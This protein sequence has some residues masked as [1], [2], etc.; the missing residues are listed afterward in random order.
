MV[1][2]LPDNAGDAKDEGWIPGSPVSAPTGTSPL[3]CLVLK[4]LIRVRLI[5][6]ASLVAQTVKK[7]CLGNPTVRGAWPA[8]VHG[9][10]KSQTRLSMHALTQQAW[11]PIE[12]RWITGKWSKPVSK[13][14]FTNHLKGLPLFSSSQLLLYQNSSPV[15]PDLMISKKPQINK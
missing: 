7:S 9:V 12:S 13:L 11:T 10:A 15:W 3:L 14:E 2:N 6:G 4:V 8:P 5:L 1:K